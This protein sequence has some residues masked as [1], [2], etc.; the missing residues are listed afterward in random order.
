[1]QRSSEQIVLTCKECGE[2]L[3]LLGPKEEWYS[4]RAIF[5]GGC[6]H[7]LTLDSYPDEEALAAS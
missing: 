2:K 1:V 6:G 7:K 4:R 3:I 5:I